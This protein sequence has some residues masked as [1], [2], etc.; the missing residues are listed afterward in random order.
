MDRYEKKKLYDKEYLSRPGVWEHRRQKQKE[1]YQKNRTRILAGIKVGNK[2]KISGSPFYKAEKY[3]Q[4]RLETL[5]AY[6]GKCECCGESKYEFLSIHH[7]NN[8]GK[9]HRESCSLNW[10]GDTITRW[11]RR[12]N[13]P[14]DMGI[15]ILC[16]NCHMAISFYGKCPHTEIQNG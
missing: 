3:R 5:A 12:N 8:D 10:G 4:Y 15:Q 11:L 1:Y 6:G 14:K 16:Y 7:S 9:K 13:F 2:E